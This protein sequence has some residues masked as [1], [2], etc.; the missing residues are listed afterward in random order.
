M[1]YMVLLDKG[2]FTGGELTILVNYMYNMALLS[3][4]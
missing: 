1:K 4:D 2:S 3:Q